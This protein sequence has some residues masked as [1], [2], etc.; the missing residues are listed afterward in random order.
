[1]TLF[2]GKG[3]NGKTTL[4]DSGERI[5]KTSC[6]MD[7]L[8]SLDEINTLLG[9]CKARARNLDTKVRGVS[10]SDILEQ[11]QQDLFVIQAIIAGAPKEFTENRIKYLE[12][13]IELIEKDLP[14]IKTFFL[15][16][17][18]ELSGLL[19]YA[20][21]VSRRVERVLISFAE[22]EGLSA[23]ILQYTNR[24]SS[25]LY[26]LVRFVNHKQGVEEVPPRY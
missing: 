23:G 18:T 5:S 2:T 17:A 6:Q 14:E 25:I 7:V 24:L 20:R 8:G 22:K 26:A 9:V 21:A 4:F 15:A 16:G 13:N 19:D 12:R 3:D 10:V 1:M 11:L